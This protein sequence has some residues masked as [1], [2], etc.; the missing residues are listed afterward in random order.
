MSVA[1]QLG[2]GS[3]FG[4]VRRGSGRSARGRAKAVAQGDVPSY[5][6]VRLPLD[7]VAP[8]PLNPR[9]NFGSDEDLARFGEELRHAQLA[10]CVVV[11]T[12]AYLGLWPEHQEQLGN[13]SYVLVNGERRYRS[14]AHVGLE[15]LDFV[16]RDDLAASKE[17][18]VD[19]LLKE[20]LEREDFDVIERARGVQQMVD[21]CAEE[22]EAGARTRAANKLRR[23][24]S[25]VTNQLALLRLPVEIQ[26]ML[27]SGELPERDGRQLARHAKENPALNSADLLAHW[28]VLKAKAAEAKAQEKAVLRAAKEAKQSGKP[29]GSLLSADNKPE[30]TGGQSQKKS[31]GGAPLLSADNTND[32]SGAEKGASAAAGTPSAGPPAGKSSTTPPAPQETVLSADN[33]AQPP[34]DT[35][36]VPH[37]ATG[38]A[39]VSTAATYLV[40]QLGTTPS[41]QAAALAACLDESELL[42]LIEELHSYL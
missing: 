29:A 14:A 12:A 26:A 3:S 25:W 18:F 7:Q 22:Q 38:D 21:V 6:L 10:A 31:G 27:S 17:D 13:V 2:T 23:D 35:S 42:Q 4:S 39:V 40:R 30:K 5:E 34:G 16:I 19:H 37:Q 24:R 15:S 28:K 1:D 11:T 8:T 36:A 41:E 9:R 20:N 32:S 33:T